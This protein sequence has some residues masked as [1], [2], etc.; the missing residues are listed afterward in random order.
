MLNGGMSLDTPACWNAWPEDLPLLLWHGGDDAI[1]DPKATA[2][3]GEK[4]RARDKRVEIIEVSLIGLT[5]R[6]DAPCPK[7]IQK[8][9]TQ[10]LGNDARSA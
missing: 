9:D 5:R 7:S 8:A 2:S 6:H 10:S 4:V 1:C 3:F